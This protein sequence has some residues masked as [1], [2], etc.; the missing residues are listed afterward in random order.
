MARWC[1]DY[2]ISLSKDQ[3]FG[4]IRKPLCSQLHYKVK[5][6]DADVLAHCENRVREIFA[7]CYQ[8]NLTKLQLEETECLDVSLNI[9]PFI[10][11]CEI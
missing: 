7:N 8:R 5:L 6:Y 1:A 9:R 4:D 3:P 11:T 10:V 2:K